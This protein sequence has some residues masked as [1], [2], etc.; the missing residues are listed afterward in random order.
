[1]L[2][3]LQC[4]TTTACYYGTLHTNST[5][6]L[7]DTIHRLGQRAFVGKVNMNRNSPD[8][9]IESSTDDSI[10]GTL[11]VI[12]HIQG[13][14]SSLITP[15][16]TP[17]FVPSCTVDL[18]KRLG[19]LAKEHNL[20]IQSHL[21]E[22][23]GEIAW[24]K[25]LHPEC[26]SYAMVYETYGL[27][28]S[29]TI[30]AHCVH[31]TTEERAL[32]KANQ[33]GISHCPSSNFCLQSGALNVRRLLEEGIDKIGLGTDVGGGYSPSIFDAIRQAI[34]ASKVVHF[35][36]RDGPQ[37]EEKD[38]PENKVYDFLSLPEAFYLATLGGAKV[39]NLESKIG[40][41]TSG[42]DFDALILDHGK[43]PTAPQID[44]FPHD[45]T[46][47]RFEKLVYLGD[48]RHIAK[49]YVAGSKVLG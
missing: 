14:H 42:K 25:E 8:Y 16:I 28:N 5:K 1:M 34:T 37:L 13:L 45:T 19:H 26:S 36:S 10:E 23:P 3:T 12:Q 20:P 24:V 49:V 40:N 48:D 31:M 11:E 47:N 32:A 29:Q 4:G 22:T 7:A 2:K 43:T 27:F 41:F 39:L 17:R 21:S 15:V 35:Q 30:M 9:Y 46:M 6:I 33:V 38:A 18:M 44:T